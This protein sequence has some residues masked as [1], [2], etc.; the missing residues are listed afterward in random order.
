MKSIPWISDSFFKLP[1]IL[2][3]L[4]LASLLISPP[5]STLCLDLYLSYDDVI[6]RHL[7]SRV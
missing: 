6:L 1:A 2:G 4:L 5:A 3:N 7:P